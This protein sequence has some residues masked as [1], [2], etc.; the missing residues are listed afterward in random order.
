M[1]FDLDESLPEVAGDRD[2][3]T[4]AIENLTRFAVRCSTKDSRIDVASRM[5]GSSVQMRIGYAGTD[6]VVDFDDWLHGRYERYE[7]NPTSIT[8]VGLGLAVARVII[9]RHGGQIWV[10]NASGIG[11]ELGFAIPVPASRPGWF[12]GKPRNREGA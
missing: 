2:R 1:V 9:E 8:G 4:Q 11:C 10:D 6:E 12:A 3:L 5:V 7:K